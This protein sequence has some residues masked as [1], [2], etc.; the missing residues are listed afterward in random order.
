MGSPLL[1]GPTFSAV[2]RYAEPPSEL[3]RERA[4]DIYG[5]LAGQAKRAGIRVGL[6][7]LNRYESNFINTVGQAAEMIRKVGSD[8]MFVHADLFHMCIEEERLSQAVLDVRDLLGYVHAGG[9]LPRPP[10]R[11]QPGLSRVLRCARAGGLRRADPVRVFLALGARPRSGRPD[12]AVARA[13]ARLGRHRAKGAGLHARADRGRPRRLAL[14]AL[15]T[16]QLCLE[17][18]PCLR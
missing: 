15:P 18:T 10:R 8:A 6:E 7:S 1:G 3:A 13:L 17:D 9:Q 12:R 5:R 4:V 2:H 16:F 11:G 14:T